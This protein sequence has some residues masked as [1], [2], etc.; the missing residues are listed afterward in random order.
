MRARWPLASAKRR[1]GLIGLADEAAK[2]TASVD[3][4]T[5]S[6]SGALRLT[7]PNATARVFFAAND[8]NITNLM[9]C[10]A[11]DEDDPDVVLICSRRVSDRQQRSPK[12]TLR[13]G[14]IGP[15][16]LAFGTMLADAASLPE[17]QDSFRWEVA[18]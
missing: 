4:P 5:D 10:G 3:D 13:D 2:W 14:K 15:R 11:F 6:R 18:I 7:S 17:L 12:A 1:L 16:Y 8:E 9:D